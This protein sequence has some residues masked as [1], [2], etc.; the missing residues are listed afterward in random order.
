MPCISLPS[1]T[2]SCTICLCFSLCVYMGFTWWKSFNVVVTLRF[3]QSKFGCL[4]G[5]V[6]SLLKKVSWFMEMQYPH[7]YNFILLKFSKQTNFIFLVFSICVSRVESMKS[8]HLPKVQTDGPLL[9]DIMMVQ[10]WFLICWME[11]LMLHSVAIH[12]VWLPYN[13]TTLEFG[14]FQELR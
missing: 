4:W 3:S 14:W 12:H 5:L 9:L 13:L 7:T 2:N 1:R 8:L 6:R 11:R 10:W